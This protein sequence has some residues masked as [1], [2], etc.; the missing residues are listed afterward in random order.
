MNVHH[1]LSR[2]RQTRAV[3]ESIEQR[4]L[5]TTNAWKAAVSGDWDTAANWSLNHVP[6]ASEDV[7]ITVSGS[8]TV[9]KSVASADSC[10]SITSTEP[11]DISGGTLMVSGNVQV[12][13]TFTISGGILAG[14]T[15]LAG[16]GGQ[17]VIATAGSLDNDTL[18]ANVLI[19][20]GGNLYSNGALNLNNSTIT[21]TSSGTQTSFYLGSNET[22]GGNGD[23][24]FAGSAPANDRLNSY[25]AFGPSTIG[26]GITI[27]GEGGTFYYNDVQ[28]AFINLGTIDS[29]VAGQTM[30]VNCPIENKGLIETTNGGNLD[31]ENMWSNDATG[32]F[33]AL[34]GGILTLGQA[35]IAYTTV[36]AGTLTETD[37][38]LEIG[39]IFTSTGHITRTGGTLTIIGTYDLGGGTL[40][41][42]PT[43]GAWALD[44]GGGVENGAVV[45]TGADRL[46]PVSAAGGTL[47][48]TTLDSN[49]PIPDGTSL[50]IT[51][52]ITLN[53]VKIRIQGATAQTSL[54][55]DDNATSETIGGSGQIIFAGAD[56]S[57]DQTFVIN[58]AGTTT[59]GPGITVRGANGR[60]YLNDVQAAYIN[61]GVIEDDVPGT[62]FQLQGFEMVN[63]GVIEAAPGT[64]N[65]NGGFDFS[66]GTITVGI[67][68]A[69]A[70][71]SYGQLIADG[72]ASTLGGTLNTP[73]LPGF[74]PSA[75]EI[76]TPIVYTSATGAIAHYNTHAGSGIS[77]TPVAGASSLTLTAVIEE[78]TL[79]HF[80][81]RC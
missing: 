42:T 55:F 67:G 58:R 81:P 49:F 51:N 76:F 10:A 38:T 12:N 27:H 3:L 75:G 77:F 26:A 28:A 52:G 18:S 54:I 48:N 68:G 29:D 37:S 59:L 78:A 50:T 8:Y 16:S 35:A 56:T 33:D 44:Q 65:F 70:G 15:V 22:L 39:N 6:T 11:L 7:A 79:P 64:I 46:V 53:N 43:T 5:L 74:V 32:T 40:T 71:T 17:G 19:P 24:L 66:Q 45:F 80:R 61:E 31:C 9:T 23:V 60:M 34:G 1:P 4:I 73:L 36:N 21:I 13:N 30:N 47:I 20:D 69:V 25:N 63:K 62:T 2:R 72:P 41:L 14:A 57:M